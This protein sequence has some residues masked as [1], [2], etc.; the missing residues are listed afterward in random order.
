MSPKPAC[1]ELKSLRR[2]LHAGAPRT[3]GP[4]AP[5]IDI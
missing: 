1:E 5:E 3:P 4:N 2:E